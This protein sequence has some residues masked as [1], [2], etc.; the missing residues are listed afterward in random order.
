MGEAVEKSV[1]QRKVDELL[2]A[3]AVLDKCDGLI[4]QGCYL[5]AESGK[6]TVWPDDELT[7]RKIVGGLI[8]R[9]KTKPKIEK[10]GAKS[11]WATFRYAEV[12]VIVW[13]YKGRK[14][15]MTKK[16]V[17]H[18]AVPETVVPAK[19]AWVEEIEE[20]V[21]ELPAVEQEIADQAAEAKVEPAPA[22]VPF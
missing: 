19:A 6:I 20:L 2:N 11:L 8:M 9:L 12:D 15:A 16:T 5:S 4:P 7:A 3:A 1:V 21:C 18:E 22:E 10:N 14:C 13:N 17:V